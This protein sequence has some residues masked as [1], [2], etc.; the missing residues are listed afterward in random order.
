LP[1]RPTYRSSRP[2]F[3]TPYI[4]QASFQIEQE[5][6]TNTTLTVGTMWTHGVHLIA[7]SA[8]DLNL[9]RP[10]GTTQY[11]VCPAGAVS[12]PCAGP[13]LTA[14][15]FDSGLLSE[16]A[17]NPNV[18]QINALISPGLNNYNSLFVQLRRRA[19][20]GLQLMTSYTWSKNIDS[21][22]VD[23]NNQFSFSNTHS[24]SLLDQSQRLSIAAVWQPQTSGLSGFTK[25]FLSH[26]TLST[27]MAFNSGR[28]YSPLLNSACTGPNLN[29]CNGSNDSLNDSAANE[30]TNNTAPGIGGAGPSPNYGL[31]SFYGPWIDEVDLGLERKFHITEHHVIS[32][33][34]QVFNLANHA[35]FYVQNGSG[36]NQTQYNPVGPTCG[37]GATLQQ[38]CY[39]IPNSGPGNF[40]T[41]QSIGQLNGP[42][43]FQFSFAYSF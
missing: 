22:G 26:W 29:T 9:R 8:Y 31:N 12:T 32:L 30:S 15:N 1:L 36:I 21:N 19:S 25:A 34:A 6:L 35:N 3:K 33:K 2:I 39:L 38:T 27:L 43:V 28:P 5:I 4:L 10:A 41:L 40:Q 16:G 23:F 37:D 42:R 24:P 20:H 14:P 13:T 18:G 11:I 17:I 7:S